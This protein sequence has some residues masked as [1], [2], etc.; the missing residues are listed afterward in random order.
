MRA[1]CR[2]QRRLV[3]GLVVEPGVDRRLAGEHHHRQAAA[4]R[5]RQRGHQL[6][7]AWAAR[8]GGHGDLAG[9]DVVGRCRSDRGVLVPDVDGVHARQFRKGGGP[10]HVAV[11]HQGEL[12]VDALGNERFGEGFVEFWHG[13]VP[14]D[15]GPPMAPLPPLQQAGLGTSRWRLQR[16]ATS[17]LRAGGRGQHAFSCRTSVRSWHWALRRPRNIRFQRR[18]GDKVSCQ[19]SRLLTSGGYP[20]RPQCSCKRNPLLVLRTR[21]GPAVPPS[22]SNAAKKFI[23]AA[24]NR[25][26]GLKSNAV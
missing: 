10:V 5:G 14:L 13:L 17:G 7:H 6:G 24:K 11:T 8:D 12:R 25:C 20:S 15:G 23:T 9:G 3:D 16:H 2:H 21:N 22:R 4:H 19:G 1:G 18:S 26:A